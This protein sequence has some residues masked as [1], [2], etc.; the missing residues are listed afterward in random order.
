M[1]TRGSSYSW[2]VN[3]AIGFTRLEIT[4]VGYEL[5]TSTIAYVIELSRVM[6]IRP[7][8]MNCP[9]TWW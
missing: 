4:A 5:E 6:Q 2:L 9:F 8:E 1:P 7:P 3:N